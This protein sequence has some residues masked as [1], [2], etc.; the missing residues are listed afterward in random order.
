M[1]W[2]RV[3]S[4]TGLFQNMVSDRDSKFTSSLWINLHNLFGKNFSFSRSHHPQT[5][6]LAE[7]IIQTPEEIIIKLCAY[8]L[9]FK[10]Y[11]GFT[12]DWCTV[13]VA[14]ELAYGTS[15]KSSNGKIPEIL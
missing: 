9:E 11:D 15:I 8:G 5:N 7:R 14:L 3:I 4:H 13:I 12:H 6:G 1:L 10:Y 2:N